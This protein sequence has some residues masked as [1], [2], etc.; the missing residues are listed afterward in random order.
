[1]RALEPHARSIAVD[2]VRVYYEV[3]GP[4][5]VQR[6]GLVLLTPWSIVHSHLWKAQV[7]YIASTLSRR[8]KAA[9]PVR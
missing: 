4:L 8:H 9:A 2:G 6:G 1:M 3:F 7:P 5:D